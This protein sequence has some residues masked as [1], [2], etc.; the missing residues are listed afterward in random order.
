MVCLAHTYRVVGLELVE[1]VTFLHV[2]EFFVC[3][4]TV[5]LTV[6]EF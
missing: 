2:L 6:G 4:S 3:M 1:E 5:F